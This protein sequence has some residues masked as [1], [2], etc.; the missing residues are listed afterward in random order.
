MPS[1]PYPIPTRRDR[2]LRYLELFGLGVLIG[3]FSELI[4][5]LVLGVLR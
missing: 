3:S 1:D 5:L 4:L 2:N